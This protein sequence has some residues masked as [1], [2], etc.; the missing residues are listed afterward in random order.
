M[1]RPSGESSRARDIASIL[2]GFPI[3]ILSGFTGVGGGEYR[4]PVLLALL[5]DVH[6]SIASNLLA[7]VVVS[8]IVFA[9]RGG[10]DLPLDAVGLALL[11][12]ASG[13]PGGYVGAIAAKRTPPRWLKAL[14]AGI[15]IATGLRLILLETHP[16]DRFVLGAPEAALALAIGFALG[17]VTGLLGLAGGE[18]RIPALILIFGLPTILAGTVSSLVAFPQLA[19]AFEKHRR[20]GHGGADVVRAGLL[21]GGSAGAGVVLGVLLLGRAEIALVTAAL[22]IAMIAAGARI[23]WEARARSSETTDV[24]ET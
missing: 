23:A 12:V 24:R 2:A 8:G 9:F 18:Y 15:L 11:M 6:R 17:V 19:V 16:S 10:F 4:A 1:N 14:L 13:V 7:G 3:G 22:G 20:L 5:R 21:M